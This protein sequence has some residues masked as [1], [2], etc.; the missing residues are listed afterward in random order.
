M[1]I[2]IGAVFAILGAAL[3][4]VLPAIGSGT[5]VSWVGQS[6]SGV[7][8]EDPDKFGQVLLLQALPGTQ[9]IYGFLAAFMIMLR[10][11]VFGEMVPLTLKQGLLFFF[12]ALPI[13]L[14]GWRTAT[15]QAE[16]SMAAVNIVAK[17]P[18]EIGKA[19]TFP[20]MVETYAVLAFLA[21]LLMITRIPI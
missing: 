12:A 8:T 21:S 18:E 20:A 5:G 4:V 9:G 6:A 11:G 7:V 14:V 3:A 16:T 19:L 2:S 15:R 10:I 17:R 13:A 1:E